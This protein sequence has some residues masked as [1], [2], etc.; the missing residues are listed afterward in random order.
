MQLRIYQMETTNVCNAKCSYCPHS[1]MKREKGFI[2]LETV[3]KVINNCKETNQKYIALHH[4]GEPLL[5]KDIYTICKMFSSEGIQ[6][7][8]SSNGLALKEDT[9]E[10]LNESGLN[11]L[12]IAMDY[13]YE[14]KV[15]NIY[16]CIESFYNK[17]NNPNLKIY[18][19]TV[20]GNDLSK[21]TKFPIIV[22]DKPKD[23]WAG[24]IDGESS[25]SKSDSCY[26][27]DYNYGVVLW[28]GDIVNCCLD[29][30]NY[31]VIGN[32]DTIQE[33]STREFC[34]CKNCVKLQFAA[35]G[36]WTK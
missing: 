23:N 3:Q 7:E 11:L 17:I 36:G 5:H 29:S 8:F 13:L 24:Q 9:L 35:D 19:H 32:I 4:M 20:E 16:N 26:F 31:D 18:I 15:D 14:T 25:L 6:T 21:F 2:S 30:D 12:R 22:M 27:L 10:K 28:N 1:T 34:L 33:L